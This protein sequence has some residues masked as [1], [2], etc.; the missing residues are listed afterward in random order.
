MM[1]KNKGGEKFAKRLLADIVFCIVGCLLY[2][3]AVNIF[4][5]PNQISQGGTTGLS[6]VTNY[7]TDLPT[8][9]LNLLF[10]IPLFILAWL[11]LG[12]HLVY[13]SLGVTVLMSVF[14]DL[15][16]LAF[17]TVQYK[18]DKLL[19]AMFCGILCGI[20]LGL[21]LVRGATSGGTDIVAKLFK[22]WFPYMS[23][24]TVILVAD[25]V[26]VAI[27][28]FVFKSVESALY[29][30]VVIFL[31]S[32][33]IDY[34]LYG[35]DKGKMIMAVTDKADEISE[36]ITSET[37]RGISIIPIKGGY[38]GD[39]KHMIICAVRRSEASKIIRMI[40]R[41]DDGCFIMIAEAGEILGQGF[42][43]FDE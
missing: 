30:V 24:G 25:A 13:K 4:S 21:V 1:E 40:K 11:F 28:A 2:A 39:E 17:P 22:K 32:K 27:S 5:I 31:S 33:T 43:S 20:G 36:K 34:V 29:A 12:R 41:T 7:L 10:N 26:V 9:L 3:A 38:T 16:K 19:A 8:G 42:K 14:I 35:A 15:F 37:P 18:G 23:V 6:I